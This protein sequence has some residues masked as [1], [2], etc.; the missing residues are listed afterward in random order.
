MHQ[1]IDGE[2]WVVEVQSKG[3]AAVNAHGEEYAISTLPLLV[4]V[5]H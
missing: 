4:A 3:T 5:V 1:D 2:Q